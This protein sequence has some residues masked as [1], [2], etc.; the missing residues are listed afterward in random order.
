[1]RAYL[2]SSVVLRHVLGQ[3][4]A[5]GEWSRLDSGVTSALTQLECLRTLDRRRLHGV[6]SVD[7]V[8]ASRA[9]TF[10]L[11]SRLIRIDLS[12]AVLSR[13]ADPFPTPLGTLDAL[14]LSSALLWRDE[15]AADLV[16]ATHDSELARAAKAC[17][18]PAIGC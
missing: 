10:D 3:P 18:L 8:A 2:D 4:N 9:A 15:E 14:H 5:L 17:G 11:L 12:P 16:L 7:E 6:L 13:A 1:M